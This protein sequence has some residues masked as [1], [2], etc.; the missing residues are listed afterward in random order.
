MLGGGLLTSSQGKDS[1][2]PR[3]RLVTHFP[4]TS[5][6]WTDTGL[7]LLLRASGL[8]SILRQKAS[9][10]SV[11]MCP[12]PSPAAGGI[13]G[14]TGASGSLIWPQ[15]GWQH[16]PWEMQ[17]HVGRSVRVQEPG[18]IRVQL[19]RTGMEFCRPGRKPSPG[20]GQFQLLVLAPLI[21]SC[22][23]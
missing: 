21:Y 5:R 18:A 6:C 20:I 15:Q 11:Q 16:W 8:I 17:D 7:L 19:R 10:S 13:W 23:T 14:A 1:G 3:L 4:V 22:V 12:G 9:P 2:G